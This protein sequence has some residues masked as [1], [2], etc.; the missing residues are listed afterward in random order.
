MAAMP[1]V[2]TNPTFISLF[3]EP[4]MAP[5]DESRT[6]SELPPMETAFALVSSL[7]A[8]LVANR[9][10]DLAVVAAHRV[11]ADAARLSPSMIDSLTSP[12]LFEFVARLVGRVRA[13]EPGEVLVTPGHWQ[14]ACGLLI[15][16]GRAPRGTGYD[17]AV[18]NAGDGVRYHP[19]RAEPLDTRP[20]RLPTLHLRGLA[21]SRMADSS[22][23]VCLLHAILLRGET[24]GAPDW[25]LV[26]ERLLPYAMQ[27]PLSAAFP[28]PAQP[29]DGSFEHDATGRPLPP[30]PPGSA[31][32]VRR[33][34]TPC[35]RAMPSSGHHRNWLCVVEAL[36]ATVLLSGASDSDAG[37][38]GS[39]AT[40]ERLELLLYAEL[41]RTLGAQLGARHAQLRAASASG[42]R[43]AVPSLSCPIR[44]SEALFIRG[45]LDQLCSRVGGTLR[46]HGTA[47]GAVG[48]SDADM[49]AIV[50]DAGEA[51]RLLCDFDSAGHAAL[52]PKLMLSSAG[53]AISSAIS[54][55]A[56]GGPAGG[57]ESR[58]GG[59]ARVAGRPRRVHAFPFFECLRRDLAAIE[60]AA[61]VAAKPPITRPIDFCAVPESVHSL[62]QACDALR[63]CDGICTLLAN[64]AATLK[65]SYASAP[66]RATRPPLRRSSLCHRH[67][68]HTTTPPLTLLSWRALHTPPSRPPSRAHALSLTPPR[69]RRYSRRLALLSHVFTRVLPLPLP[70]RHPRRLALC[71]WAEPERAR[72]PPLRRETQAELLAMLLSLSRHLSCCALSLAPLAE[73]D[74][75][76]LLAASAIAVCADATM[77]LHV[78]QS[79]SAAA[80]HYAGTAAAAC[81][82]AHG[83]SLLAL[84]HVDTSARPL[85]EPS[86]ALVRSALLGYFEAQ[87]E[88]LPSGRELF[89]FEST[90]GVGPADA[91]YLE[92][93]CL[94]VGLPSHADVLPLYYS[95]DIPDLLLQQPELAMLR[96]VVFL[97]KVR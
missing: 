30:P 10:S 97:T 94:H 28:P 62:Q 54:S 8:S 68:L 39:E 58:G 83:F 57:G 11:F 37:T 84:L 72:A 87:R 44:R 55:A 79:P 95:G 17:L 80:L 51:R 52:P 48:L 78:A 20:Q 21:A 75:L 93:L 74:T 85:I 50:R 1:M 27:R 41:L 64:Q 88:W 46:T 12:L 70:A 33:A 14:A 69:A 66:S 32:S 73:V 86:L 38:E 35:W 24:A 89:R 16:V 67:A 65:A 49:R 29:I 91:R 60:R 61:G 63:T 71:L 47:M 22:F 2:W 82:G 96:D 92:H 23:W 7:L 31:R 15:V 18:C 9:P 43:P 42:D 53:I 26:Y 36:R 56:A 19:A 77:R 5:H 81:G 25:A 3:L 76:C 6:L 4:Y 13:L 34:P 90:M 45:A 59:R 40:A